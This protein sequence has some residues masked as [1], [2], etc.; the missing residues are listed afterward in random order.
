MGFFNKNKLG[1]DEYEAITKKIIDLRASYEELQQRIKLIQTD[2]DNLRG[3]FNQRLSRIKK[4]DIDMDE[5][6]ETKSIN[7][8][9]LLS[10]NG[11]IVKNW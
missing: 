4:D 9:V 2:I 1:S 7:N 3:R 6:T 5:T 8:P 10:D 11:N